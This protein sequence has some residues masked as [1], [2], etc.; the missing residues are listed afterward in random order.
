MLF[1]W[2]PLITQDLGGGTPPP[3]SID[4]T[5]NGITQATQVGSPS[6]ELKFTPT[7]ISSVVAFGTILFVEKFAPAG[8]SQPT[9]MGA[10]ALR[11]SFTPAG[12]S[13]A[14]AV[15]APSLRLTFSPAGVSQPINLGGQA[16]QPAQEP[17]PPAGG[18]AGP[19]GGS[20]GFWPTPAPVVNVPFALPGISLGV[21]LGAHA[22]AS[23]EIEKPAPIVERAGITVDVAHGNHRFTAMARRDAYK[24]RPESRRPTRELRFIEGVQITCMVGLPAFARRR[25]SYLA[26]RVRPVARIP[27][28]RKR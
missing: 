7:G 25:R 12:I 10:L 26:Q 28:R 23:P 21:E 20:L 15:G 2:T 3:Q 11:P 27:L 9:T 16:Q 1:L 24:P 14:T 6:L 8:I 17:A 19:R 5:G 18:A 13:N 22:F 4:F